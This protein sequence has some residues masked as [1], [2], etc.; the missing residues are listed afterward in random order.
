[1]A[2]REPEPGHT[3][4]PARARVSDARVA[5]WLAWKAVAAEA[6]AAAD[7]WDSLDVAVPE[8][9][10]QRVASALAAAERAEEAYEA[11]VAELRRLRVAYDAQRKPPL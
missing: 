9:H 7:H 1:M 5:T 2:G 3:L 11:A 10:A 8:G 4:R 6:S